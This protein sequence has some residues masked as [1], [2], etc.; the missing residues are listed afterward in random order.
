[1]DRF[2]TSLRDVYRPK[3]ILLNIT[4]LPVYFVVYFALIAYQNGGDPS[5]VLP[6][7]WIGGLV[8]TSSVLATIAIYSIRNTT[9]NKARVSA[10]TWGTAAAIVGGVIGGCGCGAP[11]LLNLVIVLGMSAGEAIALNNFLIDHQDPIFL[12]LIAINIGVIVYYLNRL[13]TSACKMPM[14]GKPA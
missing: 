1:M 6:L 5:S 12:A 7:Y 3:Y 9:N 2:W 8:L 4:L 10:S 11:L 13:S 14:I